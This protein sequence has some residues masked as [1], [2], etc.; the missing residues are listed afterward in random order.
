MPEALACTVG[1]STER[2]EWHVWNWANWEAA[3]RESGIGYPSR[4]CGGIENYRSTGDDEITFDA[5]CK[6]QAAATAAVVNELPR[7]N[8]EAVRAVHLGGAWSLPRAAM[9]LYY[10]D[11]IPMIGRGLTRHGIE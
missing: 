2:V 6:M 3:S 4:A 11:S 7:T 1:M 9:G 8:Q 5:T 10:R